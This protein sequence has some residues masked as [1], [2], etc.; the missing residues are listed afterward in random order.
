MSVG[1]HPLKLITDSEHLLNPLIF[2][3]LENGGDARLL[4]DHAILWTDDYLQ[5]VKKQSHPSTH[6]VLA[7]RWVTVGLTS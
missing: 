6:G 2:K 4:S 5:H 3:S 1:H 7:R